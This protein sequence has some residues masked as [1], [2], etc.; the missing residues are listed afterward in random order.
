MRGGDRNLRQGIDVEQPE[1][2]A[3]RVE[4]AGRCKADLKISIPILLD[5]IDGK[6]QRSFGG[7]PDSMFVV[8]KD[9]RIALSERWTDAGA[10]DRALAKISG[11]APGLRSA[12]EASPEVKR[13]RAEDEAEGERPPSKGGPR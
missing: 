6:A 8:G 11:K 4:V 5:G 13:E 1:T 12:G 10:L 3:Q 7:M 2:Y 9:G